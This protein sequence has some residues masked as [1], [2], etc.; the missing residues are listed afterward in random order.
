MWT[1]I[2]HFDK[3][4]STEHI[5]RKEKYTVMQNNINISKVYEIIAYT[6]TDNKKFEFYFSYMKNNEKYA[7]MRFYMGK[8]PSWSWE[9]ITVLCNLNTK[10]KI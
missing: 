9:T 1:S 8:K 4:N 3:I 10:K 2:Y 7:W 6:Y 5:D